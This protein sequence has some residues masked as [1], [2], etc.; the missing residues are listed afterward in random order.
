MA[1]RLSSPYLGFIIDVQ[2]TTDRE[3][4]NNYEHAFSFNWPGTGF[5]CYCEADK[6][7]S[8]V[9]EGYCS[10]SLIQSNCTNIGSQAERDAHYWRNGSNICIRRSTVSFA[11]EEKYDGSNKICGSSD[12]LVIVPTGAACPIVNLTVGIPT[13]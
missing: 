11:N 13:L 10:P 7:N 5:G 9:L 12:S 2:V 8:F 4:P 3:C 1:K 6:N